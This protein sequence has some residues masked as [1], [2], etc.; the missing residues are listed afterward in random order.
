MGDKITLK[1]GARTVQGKKVAKIRKEGLVPGVVYGHGLE[2]IL[3]QAEYNVVDKV[4]KA[5]GRHTPVHINIDGKNKVTLIKDIDRDQVKHRIRHVAFHAVKADDLVVTEVPIRLVGLGESE[6]E[7]AGLIILQAIEN[8]EVKA[9]PADLPEALEISV[10]G[11]A[12]DQDKV[13]FADIKLPKG[14]EFAD[15]EQDIELVVANV[16]EPAALEAANEA[17]AGDAEDDVPV[18]EAEGESGA[19]EVSSEDSSEKKS[20]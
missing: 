14:V 1:L 18:E 7:K 15:L 4:V 2:P 9:K 20:E 17:A 19:E 8:V 11:L 13:T 6:A 16:Y 12:T 5:A 10:E 3:V